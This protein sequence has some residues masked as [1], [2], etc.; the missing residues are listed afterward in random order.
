VLEALVHIEQ[1]QFA[2]FEWGYYNP[3]EVIRKGR[4][5]LSQKSLYLLLIAAAALISLYFW[6]LAARVV[7]AN[8]PLKDKIPV[9]I[10]QWEVE[11]KGSN[12]YAL[13]ARYTFEIEGKVYHG[14]TLFAK[15]TYLNSASAISAIREN[16]QGKSWK[17]WFDRCDPTRSSMEKFS[18]SG[19]LFRAVIATAVLGYFLLFLYKKFQLVPNFKNFQ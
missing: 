2:I 6:G 8:H 11:E 3:R 4:R 7:L 15:P 9:R 10:V 16:A 1:G 18:A 17:A 14:K 19:L 5:M 13:K 12:Q